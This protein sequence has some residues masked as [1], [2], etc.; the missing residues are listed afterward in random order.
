MRTLLKHSLEKVL[1]RGG[2]TAAAR[3]LRGTGALVLAYHDVVPHG[4]SCEGDRSLHLPQRDFAR[5]LELIAR[6]H[7]VVPLDSLLAPPA[8]SRRPRVVITFDDAYRG[9]VTAGVE[10]L[11]R[12]GLPATIF[13]APAFVDGGSFWWDALARPGSGGLAP[14]VRARC[15]GALRGRDAE[16]RR[17]ARDEG[18][19]LREPPPHQTGATLDELRAAAATPGITLAAHT[20]SHPSLPALG[21]EELE[22]EMVRPLAWLRERFPGVLPWLSYPY[23]HASPVVEEA[24]R[25]AGYLGAFRVEGGWMPGDPADLRPYALP[26]SNVPAGASLEHFELRTSGLLAR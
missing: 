12:R 1:C 24:A 2:F 8:P 10:E 5:Q 26:R 18:L 19:L 16:I 7:D 14:E 17:W 22:E 20:W 6:T 23:G 3:A 9:A 4:E 15:L 25:S 21:P 13:V 11:A